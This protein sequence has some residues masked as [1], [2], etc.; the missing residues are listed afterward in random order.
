MPH[1]QD[2]IEPHLAALWRHRWS[3]LAAAWLICLAGWVMIAM[4]PDRYTATAR[5]FVDTET[6]LGP[7][8]K[9]LA[10]TPDFDRQVQ[11]MRQTLLS[12]PNMEELLRRTDLDYTVEGDLERADL[13]QSLIKAIELKNSGPNLFQLTYT[14]GDAQLAYRVVD[15][16]LQIFVEQ[17]LGHSQRD[18][19]TARAFID[20]QIA[21][22]EG[23][24]RAAELKLAEFRRAHAE[25][26]G[27]VDRNLRNL[28]QTETEL[29]QLQAELESA[30]WRRDQIKA[31]LDQTPKTVSV[32]ETTLGGLSPAQ[33]RLQSLSQDLANKQRIYTDEHPDVIALRA[34]VARA[35]AEV[36]RGGDGSRITNPMRAELGNQ[37]QVVEVSLNDLQRRIQL[38]REE[39]N[40][41]AGKVA[42]TP[43][44]EAD[45]ARLNRD[46]D[47]LL[48]QYEKLIQRRESAHLAKDLDTDTSRIE[49]RVVDPPSVP[50]RPSGPPRGILLTAV[51]LLGLAGGAAFAIARQMASESFLTSQTL[52]REFDL[53]VLG[54]V[55]QVGGPN[56]DDAHLPPVLRQYGLP[57]GA[58]LLLGLFLLLWL[59]FQL[60]AAQAAATLGHFP[61][62]LG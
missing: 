5:L 43:E 19:E 13:M 45:R 55:A 4:L 56:G 14:A 10:V 33:L 57:G 53:P 7:L 61:S 41:L 3:A 16:I 47:V 49:Y 42:Q 11:M 31:Q 8:M 15:T 23:K 54:G 12:V 20:K 60:R 24:L 35:S 27:G 38:T 34:A 59:T 2:L 21:D 29:R 52:A 17:N 26:L 37:L 22:Y 58:M 32:G 30:T 48:A 9:D 1:L 25:E 46:Y 28:E 18:V 40:Q 62:L 36:R 6:I 51:L 44:I 50:L 39:Q